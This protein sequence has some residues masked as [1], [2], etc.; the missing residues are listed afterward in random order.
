MWIYRLAALAFFLI[1]WTSEYVMDISRDWALGL[2]LLLFAAY[3]HVDG[4]IRELKRRRR[5]NEIAVIVTAHN[6]IMTPTVQLSLFSLLAS[7]DEKDVKERVAGLVN[8]LLNEVKEVR[9]PQTVSLAF[10]IVIMTGY[11]WNHLLSLSDAPWWLVEQEI[12]NRYD[13]L[14]KKK[15][16]PHGEQLIKR[17]I[18]PDVVNEVLTP[19][20]QSRNHG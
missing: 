10:R 12:R 7:E 13:E 17:L 20:S 14:T 2:D 9:D 1:L 3:V 19:P 6:G 18:Y 4:K 16:R 11:G 15:L 8:T 5:V